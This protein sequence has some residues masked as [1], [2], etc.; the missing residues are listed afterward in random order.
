M[1]VGNIDR[2]LFNE[3]QLV[4]IDSCQVRSDK[5]KFLLN[6]NLNHLQMEQIALGIESGVNVEIYATESISEDDMLQIRLCLENNL[7]LSVLSSGLSSSQISIIRKAA[8]DGLNYN[9]MV[10]PRFSLYQ[11]NAIYSCLKEG[12]DTSILTSRLY[13]RS[14]I[15]VIVAG[16]NKG[17]DVSKY[18]CEDYS[19][20][21][22]AE[23]YR[24]LCDGHDISIYS[25]IEF[26]DEQMMQIR[27]GLNDK[28]DVSKYANPSIPK[29]EME[30]IRKELRTEKFNSNKK[31]FSLSPSSLFG[32]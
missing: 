17:L 19:F 14:K 27:F 8:K 31:K 28:V 30:R 15:S 11:M 16:L 20:L 18:T 13:D 1:F 25:S 22:M 2:S 10:N 12:L 4:Q 29:E 3:E 32:R 23:I 26:N 6:P 21:Q 5:I 24:G 7:D 9:I